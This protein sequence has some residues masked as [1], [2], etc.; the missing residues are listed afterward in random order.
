MAEVG[1]LGDRGVQIAV[2]QSVG[3]PTSSSIRRNAISDL[4]LLFQ[5]IQARSFSFP[6]VIRESVDGTAHVYG[7]V[8]R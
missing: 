2:Y 6:N 5:K 7:E 1:A 4:E 8:N 3:L